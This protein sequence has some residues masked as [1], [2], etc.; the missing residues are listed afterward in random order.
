LEALRDALEEAEDELRE[1][2]EEQMEEAQEKLDAAALNFGDDEKKELK[3]IEELRDETDSREFRHGIQLI[4]VDEFEDYARELA[5]E[6]GAIPKDAGWPCTCIDW[7][8]AAK[9]LA[10]DYSVVTFRGEDYYFR[11]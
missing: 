3:E 10:M 2:S 5:D 8:Q 9:E 6:I 7:E 1:A 11:A 4:P